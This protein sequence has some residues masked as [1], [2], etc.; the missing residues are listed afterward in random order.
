MLHVE[1]DKSH[2]LLR[3]Q[4]SIP[5]NTCGWQTKQR[6]HTVT[7]KNEIKAALQEIWANILPELTQNLVHSMNK[8]LQTMIECKSVHTKY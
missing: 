2:A 7:T 6:E 1:R 4:T 3:V 8:R 5:L